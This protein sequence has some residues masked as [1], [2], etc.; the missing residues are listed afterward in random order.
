[1]FLSFLNLSC[2]YLFFFYLRILISYVPGSEEANKEQSGLIKKNFNLLL[3]IQ[4]LVIAPLIERID[5]IDKIK[6]L[7]EIA[8]IHILFYI[9]KSYIKNLS[10]KQE[11]NKAV[12]IYFNKYKYNE[13]KYQIISHQSMNVT[14]VI[15]LYDY[16]KDKVSKII[17]KYIEKIFNAFN[18]I[19]VIFLLIHIDLSS[20]PIKFVYRKDG[21]ILVYIFI[22]LLL[23]SIINILYN[24]NIISLHI[25][26]DLNVNKRLNLNSFHFPNQKNIFYHKS[27]L[28][29]ISEIWILFLIL[30]IKLN[31]QKN[32][33]HINVLIMFLILFDM[34]FNGEMFKSFFKYFK[35]TYNFKMML[36]PLIFFG[37]NISKVNICKINIVS[38]SMKILNKRMDNNAI[39]IKDNNILQIQDND[40]KFINYL[41][42]SNH[43]NEN[44]FNMIFYNEND[45]EIDN[46]KDIVQNIHYICISQNI[47]CTIRDFFKIYK[48][49]ITDEEIIFILDEMNIL[50]E[51]IKKS[52]D[53]LSISLDYSDKLINSNIKNMVKFSTILIN[54]SSSSMIMANNLFLYMN[55]EQIKK[56]ENILKNIKKIKILISQ[57]PK[58]I[59]SEDTIIQFHN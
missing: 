53:I 36:K 25:L 14:Q 22:L 51:L 45:R 17:N 35:I 33:N 28:Y 42:G 24:Y 47:K 59:T 58:P 48:S 38:S 49:N 26:G 13:I 57:R 32:E 29:Y 41:I 3:N 52:T 55:D 40:N 15:F 23:T 12:S 27:V 11:L 56:S 19:F 7:K 30:L 31:F 20:D 5:I 10:I 50:E 9:I 4:N 39:I 44:N 1:M 54:N 34:F 18:S 21:L 37:E 2:K 46:F 43:N 16:I 8:M 6:G